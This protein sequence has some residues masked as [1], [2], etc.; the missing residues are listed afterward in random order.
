MWGKGD[1][2]PVFINLLVLH[3]H[4]QR[5]VA[6]LFE[7]QLPVL[8]TQER[9]TAPLPGCLDFGCEFD[10]FLI[11]T[12]PTRHCVAATV[13]N[14]GGLQLLKEPPQLIVRSFLTPRGGDAKQSQLFH[15]LSFLEFEQLGFD[16]PQG[17]QTVRFAVGKEN[18]PKA[19][20]RFH[21]EQ[22]EVDFELVRH[23]ISCAGA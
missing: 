5:A 4:Q 6:Q 22:L 1:R 9:G 14:P 18:L 19:T 11:Q 8:L 20:N 10:P 7:N 13:L 21:Y 23:V 12:T 15:F 3:L 17:F 2:L 16:G